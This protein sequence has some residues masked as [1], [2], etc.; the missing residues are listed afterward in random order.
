[1][2]GV[3][4]IINSRS[5]NERLNAGH[6]WT[7]LGLYRPTIPNPVIS[8]CVL[9]SIAFTPRTAQPRNKVVRHMV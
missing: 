4:T 2:F 5:V 3:F 8:V 6:A 9:L 1:M 7:F